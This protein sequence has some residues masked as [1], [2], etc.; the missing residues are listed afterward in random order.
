MSFGGELPRTSYAHGV[1][2]EGVDADAGFL[3]L[4]DRRAASD[5]RV[6]GQDRVMP[7]QFQSQLMALLIR[8]QNTVMQRR[9]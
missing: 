5:S 3:E 8:Q 1:T 4:G 6:G 9:R 2:A 7:D